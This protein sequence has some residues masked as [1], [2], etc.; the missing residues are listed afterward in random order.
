[1]PQH[2]LFEEDGAFKAGTVLSGTDTSYQVELVSGKRTKVKAAHVLLRF[3]SPAPAQLLAD[4]QA[5]AYVI[6]LDFLWECAPQRE[7]SFEELARE[8]CGRAPNAVEAATILFRLHGAPVYFYRKGRGTYRPAPADVLKLALAAVERKRQQELLKQQYADELK[9]GGLPDAIR[10]QGVLLLLRPDKNSPE[11]KAV[12]QAANELQ[13][14]P[15]RL[16][17]ARG[18]IASAYRWHIETFLATSFPRGTGF[19]ADLPPPA[20]DGE[21]P[22][23]PVAA[24]SIDD[25]STTEIDDA[26]SLEGNGARLRIGIHIAAPVVA[27]GRDHPLDAV[28]RARMSTVYAPGLKYTM[29]PPAWIEA[30]SLNEGREVPVLSLYVDADEAGA[31]AGFETRV[32]RI[33]IAA[34]L[35]HD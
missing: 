33:R 27:V 12:E 34:N 6:E 31:I 22:P 4:A 15:L 29:L 2:L 28:A 20:L 3:E 8:Y 26:F 9:A 5:A 32:E 14:S 10:S 18:A 7:F 13:M 17:L 23:A 11:Y 24:F 25:S 1:M 19:A 35:R 21:L 16:L 30:Y